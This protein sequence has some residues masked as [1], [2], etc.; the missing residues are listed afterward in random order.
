MRPFKIGTFPRSCCN[1]SSTR[2]STACGGASRTR[3]RRTTPT[4][5]QPKARQIKGRF[6]EELG[7]A[8]NVL[9]PPDVQALRLALEDYDTT[10]F[11]V[12]RRLIA[13]ETGEALVDEMALMQAKQTRVNRALER[14]TA[15]D[16]REL[17]EAFAAAA[18]SD[19]TAQKYR[20]TISLVCL[21]SV[22]VLSAGLVCS[23]SF[24]PSR[25]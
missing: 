25:S 19:A 24:D 13:D 2:R 23:A 10:A 15:F 16:G 4:R 12:S 14:A 17:S 8:Q 1:R 3:S 5:S 18:R 9:A 7:A 11:D 20:L 21:V 22:V 6:L